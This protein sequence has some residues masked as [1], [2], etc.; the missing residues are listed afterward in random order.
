MLRCKHTHQKNHISWFFTKQN[1]IKS[2]LIFCEQ[3][4]IQKEKSH[5][6]FFNDTEFNMCKLL[7][8]QLGNRKPSEIG[9]YT[10]VAHNPLFC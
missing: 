4:K 9:S 2:K 3:I 10:Q 6:K 7:W 5:K 8:W 1:E